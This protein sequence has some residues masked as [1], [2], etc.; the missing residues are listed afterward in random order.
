MP[1]LLFGK[2]MANAQLRSSLKCPL[3]KARWR[4]C[5]FL[6]V[7]ALATS[8]L[9]TACRD[10]RGRSHAR[11]GCILNLRSLEGAKATWALEHR[12]TTNEVPIDSDLFGL[13]AYIC[14]KPCCPSGG[15]YTLDRVGEKPTCS[16][17]G[18]TL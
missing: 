9:L 12:K 3:G 13:T 4:R 15:N 16:V 11:S 18:H 8:M 10:K 17:P 14:N 5:G 6:L 7:V 1:V 2:D